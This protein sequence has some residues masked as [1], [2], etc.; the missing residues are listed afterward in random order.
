MKILRKFKILDKRQNLLNLNIKTF[1]D[2]IKF[3]DSFKTGCN[4]IFLDKDDFKSTNNSNPEELEIIETIKKNFPINVEEFNKSGKT[5]IN[6]IVNYKGND[7]L[8]SEHISTLETFKITEDKKNHVASMYQKTLIF[9]KNDKNKKTLLKNIKE[10]VNQLMNLNTYVLQI[11]FSRKI[12]D[13]EARN[14]I[15]SNIIS[16][17]YILYEEEKNA[18]RGKRPNFHEHMKPS[19]IIELRILEDDI[20]RKMNAIKSFKNNGILMGLSKNYTKKLANTRANIAHCQWFEDE[21]KNIIKEFKDKKVEEKT[22]ETADTINKTI[23]NNVVLED[24]NKPNNITE[25]V[26]TNQFNK[27]NSKFEIEIVKGVDLLKE[28]MNL[29]YEVGKASA[30]EP[31]LILLKYKGIP[32]SNE[33]SHCILGKGLTFDTGGVNLKPT[34]YLEDMYL[35]KHG[36]CNSLTVF[37][38]LEDLDI[39]LNV[40]CALAV[41]ENSLGGNSYRPSDII[42][43][44]NGLRVEIGNTD[45]EGRLCLADSLTYIQDK[46]SPGV[47]I[48]IATLTGACMVALVSF[49]VFV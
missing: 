48:D 17:N 46:Y 22:S 19:T 36:A 1:V 2:R 38:T 11:N 30:T 45:A 33:F 40:I 23:F 28:K 9:I 26:N 31:R 21:S 25:F 13:I 43:A 15:I 14:F 49:F 34:G 8:Q 35:D 6:K 10:S 39:K 16:S 44:R 42:T 7:N 37:K 41:A 3:V 32:E 18:N 29:F 24:F 4:L 20:F 47:I 12:Q 5:V 27:N